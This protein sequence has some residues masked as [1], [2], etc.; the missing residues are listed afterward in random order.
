MTPNALVA[1]V[2]TP[3]ALSVP[4]PR[5]VEP[6]LKVTVPVGVPEPGAVALTVAVKV[7]DCP[8]VDGLVELVRAVVVAAWLTVCPPDRVPELDVNSDASVKSALTVWLPTVRPAVDRDACPAVRVTGD[9]KLEPSMTNWTEPIGVPE[10]GAFVVTVA[11]NVTLWPKTDVGWLLVADVVV[12]A[13][14]TAWLVPA[15][16]L[17]LKLPSPPYVA[18]RVLVPAVVEVSEQV[19]TAAVAT[20]VAL[21]SETVTLPVGV[22]APGAAATTLKLTV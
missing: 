5:V 2:A 10:P 13:A 19:P 11:V 16:A 7:T 18:T 1:N 4:V 14:L 15:L 21:P 20:Q 17:V 8:Y 6:S 22:P 9:P 12:V 3:L